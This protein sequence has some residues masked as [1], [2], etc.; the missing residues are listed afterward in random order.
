MRKRS[1]ATKSER[2]LRSAIIRASD[3]LR[4]LIEKG[5]PLK[6]DDIIIKDLPVRLQLEIADEN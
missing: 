6:D 3:V 4:H 5:D 2:C 1:P